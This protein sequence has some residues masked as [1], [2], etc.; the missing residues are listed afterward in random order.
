MK[1]LKMNFLYSLF[2]LQLLLALNTVWA[3]DD[4]PPLTDAEMD[5]KLFAE[6][7]KP[8]SWG[9]PSGNPDPDTVGGA[10]ENSKT[11]KQLQD[12][13]DE[14]ESDI[15]ELDGLK[16]RLGLDDS[17]ENMPD[18]NEDPND[19][20]LDNSN[21][22]NHYVDHGIRAKDTFIWPE[23]KGSCSLEESLLD[24]GLNEAVTLVQAVLDEVEKLVEFDGYNPTSI[25]YSKNIVIATAQFWGLS[26]E[27]KEGGYI[28]F[29]DLA[30]VQRAIFPAFRGK[31]FFLFWNTSDE[32][33]ALI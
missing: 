6:F 31:I 22:D 11:M 14:V 23:G 25:E 30:N 7:V 5:E 18:F 9:E 20:G 12:L 1:F 2:G 16:A 10:D 26:W 32:L 24:Q 15:K 13:M 33:V 21:N 17:D 29:E 19:D 8:D 28:A 4:D 3:A 27:S